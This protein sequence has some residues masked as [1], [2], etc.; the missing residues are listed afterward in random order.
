MSRHFSAR[1]AKLKHHPKNPRGKR[2]SLWLIV[3]NRVAHQEFQISDY[4]TREHL[5]FLRRML[6]VA[7]KRMVLIEGALK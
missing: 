1:Y 7:L 6:G 4:S 2:Y 5:T 3:S